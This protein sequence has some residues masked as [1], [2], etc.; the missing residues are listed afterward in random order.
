VEIYKQ[1]C[2]K[3]W[4]ADFR[5]NGRRI[6]KSTR[7]TKRSAAQEA[8]VLML[9]EAQSDPVRV[10]VEPKATPTIEQFA[11]GTFLPF[12]DACTL[13]PDTINCYRNGWRLLKNTG[14]A[15]TRLDQV[16]FSD[17]DMLTVPGGPSNTNNMRRTLRRMLSFALDKKVL[18]GCPRIRLVREHKRTAVYSPAMEKKVLEMAEQPLLDIFLLVFD[19]GARPDESVHLKWTDMLWDKNL[20]HIR[21]GKTRRATRHV[22]MSDRVKQMLVGRLK[23]SKSEWVF[24][25]SRKKGFPMGYTAIS[26]R[27]KKLR[28]AAGIP[29][30]LVLYSGRHTFATD[31]LDRTGNIKLVSEVLGHASIETTG[32]YCHPSKKGLAEQINQ[33]NTTRKGEAAAGIEESGHVFGHASPV[34]Q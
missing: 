15:H 11:E 23:A 30:D 4:I 9:R 8:A 2:S 27:F 31:L 18:T 22:P 26:K 28:E 34:V 16:C 24:P 13:D 29:A 12:L 17:V 20:I 1:G 6:R 7:Q 3:Y 25:S 14:Y 5:V 19:S 10:P 33:R 32:R 21:W